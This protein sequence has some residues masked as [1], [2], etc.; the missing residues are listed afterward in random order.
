MIVLA[1]FAIGAC[2][3]DVS[4]LYLP[5]PPQNDL[6]S[7]YLPPSEAVPE[8]KNM[9]LPPNEEPAYIQME[10]VAVPEVPEEEI[11]TEAPEA[12]IDD[13]E[14]IIAAAPVSE[15]PEPAHE[16]DQDGYHYKTPESYR[17]RF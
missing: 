13:T 7:M 4:E 6:P 15:E 9:Y 14:E 12:P 5:P 11:V 2:V 8:L 16:L 17:Y 10:E 3:A 1:V